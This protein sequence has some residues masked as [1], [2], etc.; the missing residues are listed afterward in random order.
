MNERN[1]GGTDTLV[2][3]EA[4]PAASR[5]MP[6]NVR[7]MVEGSLT[8][9]GFL[10][11]FI[12]FGIALGAT[13]FNPPARMLDIHQNVPVLLLGLAVL[14]TLVANRFD[15]SIAGMATLTAFLAIGLRTN[16][17]LSFGLVLAICLGIGVAGGLLN[18]ALV[19]LVKVNTFIATLGSGGVFAGIAMVY[20]GGTNVVP[21]LG[22]GPLLPEWFT[23][24]G[25]FGNKVPPTLMWMVVGL[26][27]V[28]AVALLYSHRPGSWSRIKGLV[29][30]VGLVAAAMALLV[31]LFDLAEWIEATSWLVAVALV[32]F[33]WLIALLE[34]TVFGRYLR[35]TGGNEDAA[36][37]AGVPC[38]SVAIWAFVLG[39][40]LAALA[41]VF[42]A[43]I[44]GSA[45]PGVATGFLLPA[46]AA[47][48]LSTVVFSTGRFTVWGAVI[49]AI[50]VVW[51]NQGL[52]V[53][54]LPPTWNEVVNGTILVAAV[55]LATLMRRRG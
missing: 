30:G 21:G 20:S 5:D 52:I 40:G 6:V 18:G 15:L 35:A 39:G 34:F 33:L 45:A 9:F 2:A 29:V 38:R 24:L 49:G 26:A 22:G 14:V 32:V 44:Q 47:A 13:Y 37:L 53:A 48:F 55:A 12:A 51:V 3:E 19:E 43:A 7:K 10:V 54:G 36:R 41:G 28:A 1:L 46:F 8:F 27:A 11:I 17:E 50:C 23:N 16:E 4:T 25:S 42:L 31:S